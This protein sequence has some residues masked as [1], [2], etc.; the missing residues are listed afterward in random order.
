MINMNLVS[1]KFKN[2]VSALERISL[3]VK[4]GEFLFLVGPSGAGK[5]TLIKLLLKEENVSAGSIVVDESD[6]TDLH[7][8]RIPYLRRKMG[9]VFQDFR[10]LPN[11]TVYENVAFAM[12][13]TEASQR[14]IRKQVPMILSVVGLADKQ[15]A[16]P[17]ELSGGEQQRVSIARAIVNDPPILI[18]DEPTGN[19]DPVNSWEIMK[20]LKAIN[21]RGTTVLMATHDREI[22]DI[23]QQRVVAL[24][25][26]RIVRDEVKGGYGYED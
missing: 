4:K 21:R 26:G 8:R 9:V 10:L 11:K 24:E 18:A 13:I 3:E 2:G 1:K 25:S 23:M 19:L 5:S 6:I 22:V 7:K 16:Y 12:E 20:I 14:E 15:K 17:D